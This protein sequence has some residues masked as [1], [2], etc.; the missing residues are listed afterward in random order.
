MHTFSNEDLVIH[1]DIR[2]GKKKGG[3]LSLGTPLKITISTSLKKE[4]TFEDLDEIMARY[5]EPLFEKFQEVVN[6]RSVHSLSL[7]SPF[8]TKKAVW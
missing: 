1:K 7:D 5:V 6:H 2:E 3:H 8:I 4:E